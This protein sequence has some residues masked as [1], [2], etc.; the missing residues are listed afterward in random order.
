[1]TPR[2]PPGM[3]GILLDRRKRFQTH[4]PDNLCAGINTFV[5]NMSM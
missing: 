2:W 3:L 5:S 1:M 4:C